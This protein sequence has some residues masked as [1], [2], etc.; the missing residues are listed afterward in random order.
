M[1]SSFV[2]GVLDWGTLNMR[3]FPWRNTDDPFLILI[4]EVLLQR[5][6]A[7]QVLPVYLLFIKKY[8]SISDL[9][10]ASEEEIFSLIKPLGLVK[11]VKGI[12][13]LAQQIVDEYG[14]NIPEKKTQLLKIHW[15]GNYIAN[16]ILCYAYGI[17]TPTYDV[18][19]ARLINRFFL[20]GL[21]KP[22]DKD[23]NGYDFAS[24]LMPYA[25]DKFREFNLSIIDFASLVCK[26]HKPMCESCTINSVCKTYVKKQ[27]VG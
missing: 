7:D 18:N 21:K 27:K 17:S 3:D 2:R 4:A 14:A 23:T 26:S 5:T 22:I 11:R 9:S 6:K 20:L 10:K 25:G 12:K 15:I 24:S 1:R 8:R 19:F 16:A 13:Q